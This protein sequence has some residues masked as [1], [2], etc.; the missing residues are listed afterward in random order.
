MKDFWDYAKGIIF[1][2]A[3]V[4]AAYLGLAEGLE[5]WPFNSNTSDSEYSI[6]L[7]VAYDAGWDAGFDEGRAE[8]YYDGYKSGRSL[9]DAAVEEAVHYTN[10][11]HP[12]EAM[13]VIDCYE[14][15]EAFYEDGTPPSKEDYK[16]AIMSLYQFYEYFYNRFYEELE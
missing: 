1:V 12:E 8:G 5:W 7:D 11:W 14:N 13:M 4:A 15:G 6:D 2:F 3:L 16:E 9:I 10:G